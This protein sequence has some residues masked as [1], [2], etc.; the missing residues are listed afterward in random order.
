MRTGLFDNQKNALIFGGCILLGAVIIVGDEDDSALSGSS[1]ASFEV[2]RA[3][4]VEQMMQRRSPSSTPRYEDRGNDEDLQS[5]YSDSGDGFDDPEGYD[6]EPTVDVSVPEAAPV[7][8]TTP[9]L[10][11][12]PGVDGPGT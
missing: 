8:T 2:Q 12:R 10:H 7:R 11:E 1:D 3:E 9:G 4:K 6:P 5:F